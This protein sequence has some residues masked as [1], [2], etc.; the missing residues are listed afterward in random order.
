MSTTRAAAEAARSTPGANGTS[1]VPIKGSF[2]GVSDLPL[3]ARQVGFEQLSFWLNPIGAALTIGFSVVFVVLFLSTSG[4]STVGSLAHIRL[5][6]YYLPAFVT[7]GIMS[8]CFNILAITMVNRREM[9]LLKRLRL[10][11]LPTWMLLAAIFVNSMIVAAIQIV[12]VLLIG[13]LGYGVT[14]PHDIVLFIVVL[15]VGMLSFTA[16]GVGISTL[17]PNADAAGPIVSLVFF[18]L[19]AL[20]GLYFVI[21]PGSGLATFANIFP[22]RHMITASVDSFNAIPGT[23]VWKDLLVIAV[24]GLA[25]GFVALRRWEWSPKR[26]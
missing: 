13:W 8:S 19:V 26:G 14:G 5:N 17:V 16:M 3:V 7:Y 6:Q 23:S 12:L 24:W 18:I 11:P 2:R 15:I 9:G 20:S 22:I 4:H 25:G 10:S 21:K 1:D